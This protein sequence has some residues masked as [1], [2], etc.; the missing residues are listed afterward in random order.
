M[1]EF[2]KYIR[3][4]IPLRIPKY[5]LSYLFLSHSTNNSTFIIKPNR[6][7]RLKV[8]TPYLT[9][10]MLKHHSLSPFT[11]SENPDRR[12]FHEFTFETHKNHWTLPE[13]TV[14]TE[15]PLNKLSGGNKWKCIDVDES[16]QRW[17]ICTQSIVQNSIHDMKVE[18]APL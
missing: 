11:D 13:V 12:L 16:T 17:K 3:N 6:P 1:T 4:K 7:L 14:V 5:A 9:T 10:P 2:I 15:K 8:Q 18:V